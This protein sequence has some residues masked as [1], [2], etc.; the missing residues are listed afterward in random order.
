MNCFLDEELDRLVVG[1][2]NIMENCLRQLGKIGGIRDYMPP[3]ITQAP[4]L[5]PLGPSEIARIQNSM[6]EN[7]AL[8]W[9]GFSDN[10]LRRT[11]Q[12]HLLSDLWTPHVMQ[13]IDSI[14]GSARLIPLNKVWPEIPRGDQF[15]PITVL[16]P[17]FKFMEMRF[18]PKLQRYLIR[19][20]D[21]N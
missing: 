5:P 15:R 2:Q 10:F 1:Q 8:S 16:S 19:S 6:T 18:L 17:L 12:W 7:K 9:D 13:W 11:N 14:I 20:L 21:R 3:S 4:G